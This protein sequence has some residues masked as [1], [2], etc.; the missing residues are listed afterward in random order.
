MASGE[1][2]IRPAFADRS[3]GLAWGLARD[4]WLLAGSSKTGSPT[5]G[6][7]FGTRKICLGV[8]FGHIF[9][10]R[11]AKRIKKMAPLTG[12]THRNQ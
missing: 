2:T 12:Q 1:E 3:E 6:T 7:V 10:K 5:A 4:G 11:H 8:D 9:R